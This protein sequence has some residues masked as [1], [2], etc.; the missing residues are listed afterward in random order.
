MSTPTER[1]FDFTGPPAL[2]ESIRI[3]RS[4]EVM[5]QRLSLGFGRRFAAGWLKKNRVRWF[6]VA[7]VMGKHTKIHKKNHHV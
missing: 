7:H 1:D 4:P 2:Y 5:M 6:Q 3:L